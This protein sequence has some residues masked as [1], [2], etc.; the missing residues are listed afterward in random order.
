MR[1][2]GK[3]LIRPSLAAVLICLAAEISNAQAPSGQTP[4]TTLRKAAEA[5]NADAQLQLGRAYWNGKGVPQDFTE[6]LRW[7]RRSADGGNPLAQVALGAAY[8]LSLIHI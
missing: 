4:I 5:G 8:Y 1:R 2:F 7:Y 3:T 6:A